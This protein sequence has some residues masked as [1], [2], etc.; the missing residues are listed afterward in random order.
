[1]PQTDVTPLKVLATGWGITG[2][3][4]SSSDGLLKVV[5]DVFK[6]SECQASYQ[7]EDRIPQGVDYKRMM[8]AG[9][10]MESKDTCNGDSGGPIQIYNAEVYCM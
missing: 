2:F 6:E 9:S 8:C 10:Y 1:M 5:L 3:G 7:F 4:E